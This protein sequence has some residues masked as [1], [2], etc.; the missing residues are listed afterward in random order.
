MFYEFCFIENNFYDT[1]LSNK[2]L[3]AERTHRIK[4]K[5]YINY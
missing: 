2:Y 1:A 5:V 4:I 3:C